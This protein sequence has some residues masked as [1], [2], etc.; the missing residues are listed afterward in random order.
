MVTYAAPL[1]ETY[2]FYRAG[3]AGALLGST[4]FLQAKGGIVNEKVADAVEQRA[5]GDGR[6]AETAAHGNGEAG[7]DDSGGFCAAIARENNGNF[8]TLSGER[9][10]QRFDDVGEATGL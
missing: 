6:K 8:V 7:H 5:V 1:P 4:P 2:F 3:N 9:L 10:G